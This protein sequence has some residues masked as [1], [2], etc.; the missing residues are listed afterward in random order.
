MAQ[1]PLPPPLTKKISRNMII[2]I[3]VIAILAIALVGALIMNFRPS[4]SSVVAPSPTPTVTPISPTPSPAVIPY[5]FK[6][7]ADYPSFNITQGGAFNVLISLTTISGNVQTVNPNDVTFS[8][9]SGTSGIGCS[10]DSTSI[11]YSGSSSGQTGFASLLTLTIPETTPT[12]DY[13]VTVTAKIGSVSHSTSIL[14]AVE[15]STVTVSG[16]V[17]PSY[18]GITPYQIEFWNLATNQKYYATLTQ[19]YTTYSISVPNHEQYD[20]SVSDGKGTWYSCSGEFWLE[21]PA[22]STS[23]TR[24]FT[25]FGS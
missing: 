25:V 16:T 7:S 17:N 22:G 13:A 14:V 15:S 1:Q 21:V 6:M 12:N 3:V 5:D 10:F 23:I 9:N 11:L 8:A 24:D 4:S 18:S 2:A 20:V 19:N